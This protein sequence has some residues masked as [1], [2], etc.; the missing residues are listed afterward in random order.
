MRTRTCTPGFRDVH[1]RFTLPTRRRHVPA[2]PFRAMQIEHAGQRGRSGSVRITNPVRGALHGSAALVS[3]LALPRLWDLD[4][5]PPRR[6]A[7][8]GYGIALVGLFTVST[9]YHSVPWRPVWKRRWRRADHSM[10]SL[11]I[12]AAVTAVA[13][14]VASGTTLAVVLALQ[15]SVAGTTVALK[16]TERRVRFWLSTT[17]QIVQGWSAALLLAPMA[18]TV[19]NRVLA[20]FVISGALYTAGAVAL[21]TKRPGLWPGLFSYHEVF[22]VAV[23]I[24]TA[25]QYHVLTGHL[26]A[27]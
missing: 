4:I 12:A 24:A 11:F 1:A 6:L 21:I 15:W 18:G 16:Q 25:V 9:L 27:A 19:S 5:G 13:V 26:V 23:V 3:P 17:L 22:H 2:I 20:L 10:I 8:T 7:V 14:L